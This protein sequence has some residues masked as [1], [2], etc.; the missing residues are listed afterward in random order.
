MT[1]IDLPEFLSYEIHA[2]LTPR[3]RF[4][5]PNTNI[6][7]RFS[8]YSDEETKADLAW[9]NFMNTTQRFGAMKTKTVK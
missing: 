9:I 5:Q 4:L 2:F 3:Q 7:D 6:I 8:D 1:L